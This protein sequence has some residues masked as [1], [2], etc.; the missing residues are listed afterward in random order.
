[1]HEVQYGNFLIHYNKNH[2]PKGSKQG[3]QFVSGDGDGDGIVDDHHH[4]SKNKSDLKSQKLS[5]KEQKARTPLDKK[6]TSIRAR[7]LISGK[8]ENVTQY[9]RVSLQK[10]AK[11]AKVTSIVSGAASVACAAIAAKLYHDGEKEAA[12]YMG[13]NAVGLGVSSGILGAVSAKE[14]RAVNKY[15]EQYGR[16]EYA[17]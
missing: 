1:M 12:A 4:Y 16:I 9:E 17:K 11:N 8:A 15:N 14:S 6:E 3:G 13:A 7:R 5:R 10:E 2:A